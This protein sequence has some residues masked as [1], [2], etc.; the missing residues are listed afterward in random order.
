[1]KYSFIIPV[2]N[3]EKYLEECLESI[4]MQKYTN[5]EII[6]INDC[7]T[8]KSSLICE[9]Y[10]KKN[11]SIK[12]INN[13]QNMGI[14]KV[15]NQGLKL[16]TGDYIIFIDSD[17]FYNQDFLLEVNKILD[18]KKYDVLI[19]EFVVKKDYPEAREVNDIVFDTT[20]INDKT[21]EEILKYIYVK[22][23]INTVWRFIVK[24]SVITDNNIYFVDNIIHEDEEWVPKLLCNA[25]TIYCLNKKYY[26]YRIREHSITSAPSLYNYECYLKVANLLCKYAGEEDISYK[27]EFYLRSAYKNCFQ[28]YSGIRKLANPLKREPDKKKYYIRPNIIIYGPSRIGK[29]SLAKKI[30]SNFNYNIVSIDKLVS[31]FN[32]IFPELNISH[33]DRSGYSQEKMSEF[34]LNYFNNLSS[35]S[36]RINNI[37]YIMEGCYLNIKDVYEKVD[38]KKT[39]VIVLL[40]TLTSVEIEKNINKY[41]KYYDWT[42]NCTTEEKKLYS[43]NIYNNNKMIRDICEKSNIKYWEIADDREMLFSEIIKYV[44]QEIRNKTKIIEEDIK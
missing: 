36:S 13:K 21:H 34:S 22:R 11:N 16:A 7:S 14:S 12:Y 29:T 32:S 26:T 17:D 38:H 20:R 33:S 40:T 30:A 41:D 18:K 1:M 10:S 2:Y 6:L 37:N 19:S 5:Y 31:S 42:Y 35:Y 15:R 4:L 9:K 23:M 43:E 39:I 3:V 28:A 44:E 25:Q 27:K 8:D 24:R